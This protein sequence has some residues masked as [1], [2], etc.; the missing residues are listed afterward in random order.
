MTVSSSRRPSIKPSLACAATHPHQGTPTRHQT[1]HSPRIFTMSQPSRPATGYL[2]SRTSSLSLLEP[3]ATPTTTEAL[4]TL[5]TPTYSPRCNHPASRPHSSLNPRQHQGPASTSLLRRQSSKCQVAEKICSPD[6]STTVATSPQRPHRQCP[7]RTPHQHTMSAQSRSAALAPGDVAATSMNKTTAPLRSAANSLAWAHSAPAETR[8]RPSSERRRNSL[9]FA[10]EPGIYSTRN[11]F[12]TIVSVLLSTVISLFLSSFSNTPMAH[13]GVHH[14]RSAP[15]SL[16]HHTWFYFQ[17]ALARCS[18][19]PFRL[20]IY[21]LGRICA[22]NFFPTFSDS[23]S[24]SMGNAWLYPPT[25]LHT[26]P[27]IYFPCPDF[28][29]IILGYPIWSPNILF[30]FLF[31]LWFPRVILNERGGDKAKGAR[32][33]FVRG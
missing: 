14:V 30:V 9:D 23:F 13:V 18:L 21:Y 6:W 28:L 26:Q 31:E 27:F 16:H 24:P 3:H 11:V 17:H 19:L 33:L 2:P 29:E 10:Q 8:Q 5:R 4:D 15:L 7:I 22:T 12:A 20:G 25:P 32:L 1:F